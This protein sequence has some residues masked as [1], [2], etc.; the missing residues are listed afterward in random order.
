MR[1][2]LLVSLIVAAANAA[3]N[4]SAPPMEVA[5]NDGVSTGPDGKHTSPLLFTYFPS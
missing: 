1:L 2:A 3:V 5:Y 4:E